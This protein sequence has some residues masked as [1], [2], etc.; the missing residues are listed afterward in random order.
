MTGWRDGR[1][2]PAPEAEVPARGLPAGAAPRGVEA[3]IARL[4]AGGTWAAVI[5]L[6]VGTVGLLAGGRS[7][8]DSGW[9]AFDLARLPADLGSLRAEGFLWLGLLATL[10]TPLLRVAAATLGF[11]KAGERRL[12]ALGVGVLVVIALAVVAGTLGG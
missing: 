5:L 1:G 6:A 7:P 9:P 2:G 11:A 12:A 3:R 8:L 4:L 10:A